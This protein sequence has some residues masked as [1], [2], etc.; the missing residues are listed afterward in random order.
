MLITVQSKKEKERKKK[1]HHRSSFVI[2][3]QATKVVL[4]HL[5]FICIFICQNNLTI[6]DSGVTCHEE[7][8]KHSHFSVYTNVKKT[9]NKSAR[10]ILQ[11][12]VSII[13]VHICVIHINENKNNTNC[14]SYRFLFKRFPEHFQTFRA[15]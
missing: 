10:A 3:S 11:A 13:A 12:H 4:I 8:G 1:T 5:I 2:V 7:N 14:N 6:I 15:D 9:N